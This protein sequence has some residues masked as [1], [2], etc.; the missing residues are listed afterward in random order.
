MFTYLDKTIY[1]VIFKYVLKSKNNAFIK[2]ELQNLKT[3]PTFLLTQ[4]YYI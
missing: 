4:D 2:I 3:V 1:D